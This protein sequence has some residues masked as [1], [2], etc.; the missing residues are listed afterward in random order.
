MKTLVLAEKPS[1]AREIARV[2]GCRTNGN[3]YISSDKY[4]VTWALGHLVTLADPEDYDDKYKKWSMET[5]PMLPEKFK[6]KVI[7]ET[8]KQFATVKNLL[9]SKEVSSLVIA[10]D[11]GREGELVARW[12]I[13]KAGFSK[14]VKR[15][16]IS[17]QT[18]KWFT[19]LRSE[20]DEILQGEQPIIASK[21][22]LRELLSTLNRVNK[23]YLRIYIVK[24]AFEEF[25][26]AG[27]DRNYQAAI[28][29]LQRLADRYTEEISELQKVLW[30]SELRTPGRL[31][32]KRYVAVL[33]N[34]ELRQHVFG[35]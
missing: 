11:A 30:P 3:G 7:P 14:P 2:L 20:F 17:S 21:D 1:V 25:V 6:L 13:E 35:F 23:D 10:T 31:T 28:I 4:I 12:I 26:I 22:Y 9:H 5:L 8:A 19:E 16:W 15:L 24:E 18:E 33:S 34:K 32:I 27:T 29:L